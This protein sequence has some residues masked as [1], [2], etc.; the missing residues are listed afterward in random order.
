MHMKKITV[1]AFFALLCAVLLCAGVC[2]KE[3]GGVSVPALG[4]RT[5]PVL[6]GDIS[7][8]V[9]Q[10]VPCVLLDDQN[11]STSWSYRSLV[12][13]SCEIKL[14]SSEDGI[15]ICAK[16]TDP[17]LVRSTGANDIHNYDSEYDHADDLYGYNGDLFIFA[18][19]PM[20]VIE[21]E[22]S[23]R[24][25]KGLWYTFTPFADGALRVF[26]SNPSPEDVTGEIPGAYTYDEN[27]W[28][29]EA[30]IPYT[31]IAADTALF[32]GITAPSAAELAVPGARLTAMSLYLDRYMYGSFEPTLTADG[33]LL[34]FDSQIKEYTSYNPEIGDTFHP[35]TG[36]VY[37]VSRWAN[38]CDVIPRDNIPGYLGSGV[39][40]KLHG[41]YLTLGDTH[42]C[43]PGDAE[44]VSEASCERRGL[45]VIRC[46]DC[47]KI[48]TY[49]VR[50][51]AHTAGEWTVTRKASCLIGIEAK[52]C[53]GCGK[54]VYQRMI[55][56]A[57]KHSEGAPSVPEW[58]A[59]KTES[60]K[61]VLYC[62]KCGEPVAPDGDT[63][64]LIFDD[65]VP[66]SWYCRACAEV[67]NREIMSGNS[68]RKFAPSAYM[69]RAMLVQVLAKLAKADTAAYA[70]RE[71]GFDDV[72]GSAW[73]SGAVIW[74]AENGITGGVG[75]RRF[76]PDANVTREQISLFLY[77]F[78]VSEGRSV[79]A[80]ASLDGYSDA[81]SISAWAGSSLEWACAEGII[82]GTGTRTLSPKGYATRAQV[83]Q[84]VYAYLNK[85]PA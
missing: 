79:S 70:G 9:W 28:I 45:S 42:V 25:G 5:A 10:S 80:K 78:A 50:G 63:V 31:R 43:T 75:D 60:G 61:R 41:M 66:G 58:T 27:G 2:A 21:A 49:A 55:P 38:V 19:D 81:G 56:A 12:N 18:L 73:F 14:L 3:I 22:D 4:E 48:L 51:C 71:S 16:I 64:H 67:Y 40:A 54:A 57:G 24:G 53:S 7:D 83:A 44:T 15:Y 30:F 76:A 39:A 13:G 34:D 62:T 26:R 46:A 32:S 74:A 59:A 23:L 72:P 77:R 8:G 68:P 69:T 36:T 33:Y 1:F 29:F 11:C 35:K 17:T 84:M 37:T 47:G 6:D 82:S 20:G 85:Q 65:M 52:F